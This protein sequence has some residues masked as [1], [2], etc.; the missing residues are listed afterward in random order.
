MKSRRLASFLV[1][2]ATVGGVPIDPE[3]QYAVAT[4]EYLL[5]SDHEFPTLTERHRIGETGIQY[6]V[7]AAYARE[8]GIDPVI[9]GRIVR[10]N[11]TD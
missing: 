9:E 5:H 4:P 1:I 6:E 7:L 2:E 8:H 11:G 10:R 3:A